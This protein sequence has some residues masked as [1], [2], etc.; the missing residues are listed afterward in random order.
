MDEAMRFLDLDPNID[1][2]RHKFAYGPRTVARKRADLDLQG[3]F[4]VC[5]G[6]MDRL[7]FTRNNRD[8][9]RTQ[10]L[11]GRRLGIGVTETQIVLSE[12]C[13]RAGVE[14][15]DIP[16]WQYEYMRHQRMTKKLLDLDARETK[17]RKA[18]GL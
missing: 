12:I 15:A 1:A 11:R 10:W 17:L 3:Y 13:I 6:T 4:L 5:L 8:A 16:E 7:M 14:E 18:E 2:D 9:L